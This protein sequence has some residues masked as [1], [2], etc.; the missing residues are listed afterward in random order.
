MKSENVPFFSIGSIGRCG[1]FRLSASIR[2]LRSKTIKIFHNE[3]KFFQCASNYC[4]QKKFKIGTCVSVCWGI[5]VNLEAMLYM[6]SGDP[7]SLLCVKHD[8]AP[9]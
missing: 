4:G 2:N 1:R 7:S 8:G 3:M 5:W 9:L 6:K